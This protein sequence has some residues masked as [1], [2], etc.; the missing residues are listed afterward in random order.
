MDYIFF[1]S[2]SDFWHFIKEKIC[3]TEVIKKNRI[4]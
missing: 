2:F 1:K 4:M 3:V